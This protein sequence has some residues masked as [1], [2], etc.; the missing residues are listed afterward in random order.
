MSDNNLDPLDQLASGGQQQPAQQSDVD[1]LDALAQS[2]G[3]HTDQQQP[4]FWDRA[5]NAI[6]HPEMGGSSTASQLQGS[7]VSAP[8]QHSSVVTGAEKGL[9]Q[10]VGTVS[11]LVGGPGANGAETTPQGAGEWA[12]NVLESIVEAVGAEGALKGLGLGD[13]LLKVQKVADAYEKAGPM[14]RKA[15]EMTLNSARNSA[16]GAVVGGVHGGVEGAE[17]GAVGGAIAE[18]ASAVAGKAVKAAAGAASDLWASATG[19]AIQNGLQDGIKTVAQNAAEDAGT[20]VKAGS[21]R[22]TFGSLADGVQENSK[23]L[24]ST[25]DEATDGEFTNI[26]QKIRNVEFKLREIAGTDDAA[27]E[28]LFNQKVA[29]NSKLDD[30]VEQATKNGVDPEVGDKTRSAWKQQSA[31]RDLDAAVK[32]ATEGN[33]KN[34]PEIVDPKKLVNRLQ[35]LED[36]GRLSE[37]LGDDRAE[38]LM[39]SAYDSAKA[40]DR[41]GRIVRTAKTAAG[42]ATAG[43][44]GG[45]VLKVLSGSSDK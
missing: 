44:A 6:L 1:P 2:G 40:F 16:A 21:I 35:K 45:T 19:K 29:L 15:I 14:A 32:G 36:S 31:L 42:L 23:A 25:I 10:T 30:A 38:E 28:R 39:Q 13:R 12:G 20:T 5:K 9:T 11:H 27:E 26:Q 18:P 34:A 41:R 22:K 24:Y 3:Q 37:A 8:D 17:A 33:V 7:P 43:T 4:S